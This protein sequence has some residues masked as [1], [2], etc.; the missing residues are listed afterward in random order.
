MDK[1][2]VKL[3]S[4]SSNS[5]EIESNELVKKKS[6]LV[7]CKYS[8]SYLSFGFTWCSDPTSPILEFILCGKNL[9]NNLMV[10]SKLK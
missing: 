8:D 7:C 4:A 10:P 2:I 9:S 3:H 5:T 1:L 6:K